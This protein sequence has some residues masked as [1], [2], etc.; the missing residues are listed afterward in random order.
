MSHSAA[1]PVA[2]FAI[3]RPLAAALLGGPFPLRAASTG[4]TALHADGLN[5]FYRLPGG[6]ATGTTATTARWITP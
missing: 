4:T 3:R 5:T 1:S 6:T 2:R